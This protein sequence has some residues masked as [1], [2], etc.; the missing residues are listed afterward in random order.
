MACFLS[1][2]EVDMMHI[3]LAAVIALLGFVF[4]SRP[5]LL[6]LH[7]LSPEI[8]LFIKHSV[9]LLSIF[10]LSNVDPRIKF[11]HHGQAV[12]VLLLYISFVTIFNYQSDWIQEIKADNVGDQTIDGAI[13]HRSREILKLSPDMSRM[14]T[15][16]VI[17]FVLVLIGSKLVNSK[18]NVNID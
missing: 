9:I 13:Y 5:W 12:G 6:W 2:S 4:T 16:V 8:G 15:F 18:R 3:R 11:V 10:V 1:V 7:T 17:P 14:L